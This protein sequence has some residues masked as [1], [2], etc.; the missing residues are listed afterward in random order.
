VST[1]TVTVLLD[2][3]LPAT[4]V[5]QYAIV[6]VVRFQPAEL[7][8]GA[9]AIVVVGGVVL[10]VTVKL[11]PP[12]L[13]AEGEASNPCGESGESMLMPVFFHS[14]FPIG[15]LVPLIDA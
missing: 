14:A 10:S 6:S 11:V 9:V 5:D 12:L 13:R 8:A 7:G 1:L 2:S 15:P 4:S 3:T